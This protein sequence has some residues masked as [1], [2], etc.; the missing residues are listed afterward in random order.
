MRI[1]V[2]IVVYHPDYH[3]LGANIDAIRTQ[4]DEVALFNND[5]IKLK[6]IYPDV[7][8]LDAQGKNI[9]IA[10]ALN[11]LCHY[12]LDNGY[13]WILTLD[14]DSIAPNGMIDAF[15]PYLSD[16]E[17]ALICPSIKDR[18]YG[19]LDD[20]TLH[21]DPV[22]KV[23]TCITSGSLL[24]LSAWKKVHGFWDDL[25]IDMVD[26]DLCWSLQEAGFTLLRVNGVALDHSIGQ[27]KRV[28]LFGKDNVA[29][30]HSPQRCYYII[31]NSI[32]VGKKHHRENQCSRWSIKRIL[33]I[34]LYEKSRWKK[35]K[36]IVKGIIDGLRFKI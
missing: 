36:M 34:N 9:G 22:T 32:I 14:Q 11:A 31:R 16:S 6:E 35:N 15:H 30:N 4:V 33:I 21:V 23:D 3:L 29:F 19:S 8:I 20:E 5:A 17:I 1:L 7:T 28:R 18:N 26:F 2:G 10:S 12:A 24:R 13:E 27:G 25:F